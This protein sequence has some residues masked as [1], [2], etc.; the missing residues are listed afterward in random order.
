MSTSVSKEIMKK[1]KS[2]SL[3]HRSHSR[4][5][6]EPQVADLDNRVNLCCIISILYIL[7]SSLNQCVTVQASSSI[8]VSVFL[9]VLPLECLF[10]GL[11][12]ELG[13]SLGGTCVGYAVVI[14][15]NYCRYWLIHDTFTSCICVV[16]PS[17]GAS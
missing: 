2:S 7:S 4:G 3:N 12:H 17:E 9:L 1:P 6:K 13:N 14:P 11:F 5:R 10:H 16:S 15:T 8:F